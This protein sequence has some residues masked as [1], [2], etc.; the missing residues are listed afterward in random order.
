MS[1]EVYYIGGPLDLTKRVMSNREPANR[2]ERV[3]QPIGLRSFS[4][5]PGRTAEIRMEQ[6][7]YEM[8]KVARNHDAD[9]DVWVGIF[10]GFA[11]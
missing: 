9:R 6:V 4:G 11:D 10:M 2:V 5:L 8:K 7:K 3:A 1:H